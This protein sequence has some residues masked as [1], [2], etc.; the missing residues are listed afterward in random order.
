MFLSSYI[1]SVFCTALFW[2]FSKIAY[3]LACC[4]CTWWQNPVNLNVTLMSFTHLPFVD[5]M[6]LKKPGLFQLNNKVIFNNEVLFTIMPHKNKLSCVTLPP[7]T[8]T[9]SIVDQTAWHT[10]VLWKCWFFTERIVE[11][12]HTESETL[13]EQ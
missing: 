3:T 11:L 5:Q 9:A 1:L 10:R 7:N 12:I 13:H 6:Q 8:T 2:W 4:I